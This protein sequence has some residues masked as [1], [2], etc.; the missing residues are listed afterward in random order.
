MSIGLER[1]VASA[2]TLCRLENWADKLSA[3]QFDQV[4]V[5]RFIASVKEVPQELVR[6]FDATDNPLHG[7]QDGRFFY[8]YYDCYCYLP[9]VRVLRSVVLPVLSIRAQHQSRPRRQHRFSG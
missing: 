6:D 5:E 8:G 4:L 2:S 7:Q 1:E 9:L 3:W